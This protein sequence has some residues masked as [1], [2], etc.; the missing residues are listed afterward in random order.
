MEFG[1]IRVISS[2][3]L[4]QMQR[5]LRTFISGLEEKATQMLSGKNYPK[6]F[7]LASPE[8]VGKWTAP[9]MYVHIFTFVIL[10]FHIV[11]LLSWT[12]LLQCFRWPMFFLLF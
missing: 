3:K 11:L 7:K 6:P 8:Q 5:K 9:C 1:G 4:E 10:L 2:S 12:S